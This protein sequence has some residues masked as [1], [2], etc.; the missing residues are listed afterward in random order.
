[1]NTGH[2]GRFVIKL[3]MRFRDWTRRNSRREGKI[4]SKT[5]RFPG[6]NGLWVSMEYLLVL[7]AGINQQ[8]V[9]GGG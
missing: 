7:E 4:C 6:R 9:G 1:M 5:T 2:L 8:V 3:G